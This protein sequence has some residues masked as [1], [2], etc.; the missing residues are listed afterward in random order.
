MARNL[1]RKH[2][3]DRTSTSTLADWL[4][5]PGEMFTNATGSFYGH[6]GPSGVGT[7]PREW[8][9][10]FTR[11]NA[12]ITYAVYSY[13]TPI[14]WRLD[15]D[16]WIMPRV[17]YSATTSQHQGAIYRAFSVLHVTPER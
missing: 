15:N 12:R 17:Q 16:T 5:Y 10:K 8:R 4:T 6:P 2:G 7:L 13:A 14:A 11:D 3:N 1:Y 9:E